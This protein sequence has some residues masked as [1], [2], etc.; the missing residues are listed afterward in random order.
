MALGFRFRTKGMREL[1][2]KLKFNYKKAGPLPAYFCMTCSP[3]DQSPLVWNI[4]EGQRNGAKILVF[5]SVVGR[6]Y[7]T[8]IAVQTSQSPYAVGLESFPGRTLQSDGWVAFVKRPTLL[9]GLWGIGVHQID[10]IIESL[11][12]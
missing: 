11:V 5:D 7:R 1:A 8:V 12:I 10:E 6:S 9:F 3:F 4:L 2:E